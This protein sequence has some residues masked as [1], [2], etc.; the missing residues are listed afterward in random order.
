MRNIRRCLKGWRLDRYIERRRHYLLLKRRKRRR[1][2]NRTATKVSYFKYLPEDSKFLMVVSKA[3][4]VLKVGNSFLTCPNGSLILKLPRIFDFE[5]NY[6]DSAHV[7]D[8][9]R[10]ALQ[11]GRRISY[12]NFE[13]VEEVSP[14]CMMVFAAYAD[15]WKMYAPNVK[16]KTQTW[17]PEVARRFSEIGFFKMLGFPEP[18]NKGEDGQ[19]KFMPIQSSVVCLSK[20]VDV[21]HDSVY[22]QKDIENFIGRSLEDVRMYDSVSEAIRNI[23]D[24]AYKGM[25][26]SRLP[27]KWWASVAYDRAL[28]ELRIIVFDHG[29]GIP[30]TI[31][32]SSTFSLYQRIIN[33]WSEGA[34][35]YLA[36][37]RERR[38]INRRAR[39][40]VVG[41][42]HGCPDIARLISAKDENMVRDGSSLSV[43][44]G[45]AR[46]KLI[47]GTALRRGSKEDL[48]KKLQGT[49]IEWRICL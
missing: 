8:I 18:V 46:Y 11:A 32:T 3:R 15:M 21:G 2:L 27:F 6:S 5:K 20:N 33:N 4:Y 41:R 9:F 48:S 30:T 35:L 12:I 26:I 7:I 10:R 29:M 24:H 1:T 16:T 23:W 38:K 49:L 42:G 19:L 44:S 14:A 17:H 37:E 28:N 47:G 40:L 31:K 43:I 34:R 39:S 22:L 13:E 36:F 45:R 25:K